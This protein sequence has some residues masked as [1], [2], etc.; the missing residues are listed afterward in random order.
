[1]RMLKFTSDIASFHHL[2]RDWNALADRMRQPLLR[3]EWFLSGIE[4]FCRASDL[5][6]ATLESGGRVRAI[7]PLVAVRRGAL[8]WFELIG[9]ARL[10]EP[11]DF[12]YDEPEQAALLARELVAARAPLNLRRIPAASP[13]GAALAGGSR[14]VSFGVQRP[15]ADAVYVPVSG[16]WDDYCNTLSS[17]RRYDLRRAHKRAGAAVTSRVV[18][19]TPSDV[20]ALFEHACEIESRG[21][22]GQQRSALKYNAPLREFFLR[23]VRRCAALGSLRIAWLDVGGEPC[24]MQI[25]VEAYRRLWVLKIGYDEAHARCSPGMLLTEAALRHAFE[26][27]LEGYEFLGSPEP[28]LAMWSR[29]AHAQ[30][31]LV[32]YPLSAQGALALA[33]DGARLL[34]RRLRSASA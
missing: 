16:S 12:L 32:H 2:E 3:H 25:M 8:R 11:A 13:V 27:G 15:A 9:A 29:T 17:Q 33:L 7:A 6:V 31:S 4:A 22:K 1:M 21:W 10:Y 30:T 24:A 19:P 26:Q 23:Y 14:R 20:D 18:T 34:A 5:R 28:W